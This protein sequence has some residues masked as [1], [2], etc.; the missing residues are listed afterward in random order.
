MIIIGIIKA[1]LSQ[2]IIMF[3]LMM[4]SISDITISGCLQCD[5]FWSNNYR[6]IIGILECKWNYKFFTEF[7]L[8]LLSKDYSTEGMS[9]SQFKFLQHLREFGLVFQ[10]KVS[11][12]CTSFQENFCLHTNEKLDLPCFFAALLFLINCNIWYFFL[13]KSSVNAN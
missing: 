2:C 5:S 6:I 7:Y 12:H 10:R 13:A 9:E 11:K 4:S 1:V 8:L 3:Y